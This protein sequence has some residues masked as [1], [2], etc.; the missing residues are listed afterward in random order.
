MIIIP[1]IS[2]QDKKA[3][4][5]FIINHALK[6]F[7]KKGF[8]E[9][10]MDDIVEASSMSK[11]GIYTYFKSKEEIFLAIAEDR[12]NK[13]HTLVKELNSKLNS[14]EKLIDYIQWILCGLN[15]EETMLNARFAFEFW[16]VLS[17]N[18]ET[19][20]NAKERYKLFHEDLS[21]LLKEGVERG[22]FLKDL[23][24]DS[25]V[26]IILSTTDGIAFCSSVMG[27]PATKETIENYIDMILKKILINSV[28]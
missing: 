18:E 14:R 28:K 13:R 17:R 27:I 26:Y 16:S 12:F 1:K 11:G 15:G 2:E 23:D 6:L 19:S 7:S 8:V 24:I 4:R 22:E 25:M 20:Q 5:D 9:T 21:D 10:T 3:K